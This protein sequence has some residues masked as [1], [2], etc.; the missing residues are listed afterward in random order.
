[1][2][3][4]ESSSSPPPPPP[5]PPANTSV[6]TIT[7]FLLSLFPLIAGVRVPSGVNVD[8]R[9]QDAGR[10]LDGPQW[11]PTDNEKSITHT[12]SVAALDHTR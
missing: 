4:V 7:S 8:A 2:D 11:Q 12:R 9:G 6:C 3:D 1:M 5:P 10:C